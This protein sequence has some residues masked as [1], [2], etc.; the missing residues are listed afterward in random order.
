MEMINHHPVP[1][2]I[3][4]VTG[5]LGLSPVRATAGRAHAA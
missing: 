2:L 5:F 4:L 1:I 3:F